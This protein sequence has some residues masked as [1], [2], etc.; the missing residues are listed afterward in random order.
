MVPGRVAV[1]ALYVPACVDAIAVSTF[2]LPGKASTE[3]I[4]GATL[5][6]SAPSYG[7]GNDSNS[8]DATMLK[9]D[10]CSWLG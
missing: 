2:S 3:S 5:E 9:G 8:G 6:M 1:I 10:D 7:R 4:K